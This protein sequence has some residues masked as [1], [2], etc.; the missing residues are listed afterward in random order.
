LSLKPGLIFSGENSLT[1]FENKALKGIFHRKSKDIPV[2]DCGGL[3]GCEMFSIQHCN[4]FRHRFGVIMQ[5]EK[6]L[7]SK[8]LKNY[9][10]CITSIWPSF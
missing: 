9:Y 7:T 10:I 4:L 1:V 6:W 2:T 5:L 8:F 3:K